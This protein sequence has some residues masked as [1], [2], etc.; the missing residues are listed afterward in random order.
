ML[1]STG[2]I[3]VIPEYLLNIIYKTNLGVNYIKVLAPFFLLY[4][5]NTP[6]ANALQALDMSREEMN[7]TLITSILKLVLL[8]ILSLFKIGLYSLIL[9]IIITLI[10]S[11]YLHIKKIKT[12][13][14]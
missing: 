2:I 14:S 7:I 9:S 5:I 3:F 10:I 11:T 8:V 4:F 12:K 13:L 1:F 6:L